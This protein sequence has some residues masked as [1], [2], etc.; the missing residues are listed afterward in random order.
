MKP[1]QNTVEAT[2]E[3]AKTVRG[4]GFIVLRAAPPIQG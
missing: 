4:L 2:P 1:Y 3:S